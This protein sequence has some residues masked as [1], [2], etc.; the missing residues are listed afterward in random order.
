MAPFSRRFQPDAS[1]R[2]AEPWITVVVVSRLTYRKA[3]VSR[4]CWV[5]FWTSQIWSNINGGFR[6]QLWLSQGASSGL[7]KFYLHWFSIRKVLKQNH[8]ANGTSWNGLTIL[9]PSPL[10]VARVWTC[11]WA[12]CRWF[13]AG[14]DWNGVDL[15]VDI[16][17][18]SLVNPSFGTADIFLL[19]SGPVANLIKPT[20]VC[21]LEKS[22]VW[23]VS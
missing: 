7:L 10:D 22:P 23:R 16:F 5:G 9:Y 1:Q 6:W 20:V 3:G 17:C 8:S 21:N 11:W 14:V 18:S 2:S 12:R 19:L 4:C 13:A 15:L